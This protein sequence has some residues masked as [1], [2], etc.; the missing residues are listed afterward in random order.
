MMLAIYSTF[1]DPLT[2]PGS[3]PTRRLTSFPRRR[4]QSGARFHRPRIN[5]R[6]WR[7]RPPAGALT[8]VSSPSVPG[9]GPVSGSSASGGGVGPPDRRSADGPLPFHLAAKWRVPPPRRRHLPD[10]TPALFFSL[11]RRICAD[12]L[13]LAEGAADL[14]ADIL[15]QVVAAADERRVRLPDAVV[16]VLAG[17]YGRKRPVSN[18]WALEVAMSSVGP[19]RRGFGDG[20]DLR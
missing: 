9:S 14:G 8:G 18:K 19:A 20:A 4:A 6:H 1:P 13:A 16:G 12:A 11:L 7:L 17:I 5:A 3:S 15:G 10:L 2:R